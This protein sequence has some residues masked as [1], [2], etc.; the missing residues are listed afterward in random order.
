MKALVY[1]GARLVPQ[2]RPAPALAAD[3][4]LLKTSYVG[5]CLTEKHY[6]AGLVGLGSRS[7]SGDRLPAGLIWGHE[8]A[9]TVVAVGND[10]RDVAVGARVAVDP[11]T[12][13]GNCLMCRAGAPKQCTVAGGCLGVTKPEGGFAELVEV[14]EYMC[15]RVPDSV[16]DAA[17]AL[18]EVLACATRAVRL[19]SLSIGDNVVFFGAEDWNLAALQWCRAAGAHHR[20]VVD[21]TPVR[22]AAAVRAGATVTIDPTAD[23]PVR[24]VMDIIPTGADL[25]FVAME[26]YVASS[27]EYLRQA[28]EATRFQG[29]VTIFRIF[30]SRPWESVGYGVPYAKEISIKNC[31]SFWGEE[32][33]RGGRSRGDYQLTIDALASGALDVDSYELGVV[34][35]DDIGSVSDVERI[36]ASLPDAASKIVYRVNGA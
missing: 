20:I 36:Y 27:H 28:F 13:C 2:E 5:V 33:V 11:R 10:V 16:T 34:S 6:L 26:E 31:A 12:R 30:S 32:P 24:A 17:A 14:K 23:D 7:S 19:S 8:F 29:E 1:D 25:S 9:G 21:P 35:F 18:V 3:S 15:Y 4:V 22:R